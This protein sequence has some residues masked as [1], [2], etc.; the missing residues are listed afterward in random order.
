VIV[1]DAGIGVSHADAERIF[2]RFER[3]VPVRHYGGL[4]LGLY[5][6]RHIVE[7]H[8]GSIR[9]VSEEGRGA[10]FLI[11]LPRHPPSVEPSATS[12]AELR[13]RS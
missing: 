8:G 2:G 7:A 4:G 11:D 1:K 12:S 6:A 9:V 13:D 5:I 3:A 10:T